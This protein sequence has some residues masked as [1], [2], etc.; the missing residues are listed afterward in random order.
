[1]EIM[2]NTHYILLDNIPTALE[3]KLEK[4]HPGLELFPLTYSSHSPDFILSKLPVKNDSI[5]FINGRKFQ[6][7]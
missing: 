7:I 4:I 5:S 6:P 2:K 1:M 3:K